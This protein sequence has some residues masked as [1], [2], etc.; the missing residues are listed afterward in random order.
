MSLIGK[1][2]VVMQILLSVT[3]M[4]FAVAV[5]TYQTDWKAKADTEQQA[6]QQAQAEIQN[7]Q[8][9]F[10]KYKTD[11]T[12]ALQEAQDVAERTE[13]ANTALQRQL[14]DRNREYERIAN[15]LQSQTTLAEVTENEASA[16]AAE[17]MA[18]RTV[19]T[20][21]HSKLKDAKDQLRNAEDEIHGLG[22]EKEN[23]IVRNRQLTEELGFLRKVV[24]NNN[25]ETDPRVYAAQNDPPPILEGMVINAAENAKGSVDLVEISLGSDD[26]LVKG[27]KLFVFR[28]GLQSDEDAKYLGQIELVFVDSDHAVGTVIEKAKS[29]IIK[30]GDNVT[31][32]L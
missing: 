7:L 17:A 22:V 4:G 2:F 1:F 25:L 31:S 24:R 6:K 18:Q 26:G 20:E 14:E 27:H 9:E 11:T 16:R 23:L 8:T 19:N 28:S 3:F 12:T 32:K 15:D 29:G 13:A 21:L 30:K 5:F 10:D